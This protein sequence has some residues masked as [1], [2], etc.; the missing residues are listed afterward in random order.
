MKSLPC[1]LSQVLEC[2]GKDPM[3]VMEE[4]DLQKGDQKATKKHFSNS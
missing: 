4:V 3:V 1:S 2:G